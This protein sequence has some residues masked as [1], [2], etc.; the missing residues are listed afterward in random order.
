MMDML[1][2]A[3]AAIALGFGVLW[4]GF[5]LVEDNVEE[6]TRRLSRGFFGRLVGMFGAF[7]V[8]AGEA[9]W[10]ASELAAILFDIPAVIITILGLG[11]MTG[12]VDMSPGMF[13]I[14]AAATFLV[15]MAI[16]SR[17]G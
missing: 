12:H 14:A 16:D 10:A 15:S 13:L 3:G 1:G 7:A 8:V 5:V 2:T 9:A 4:L 11:G 6:A 17:R